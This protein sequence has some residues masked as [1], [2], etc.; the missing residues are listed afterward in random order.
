MA[1]PYV[2]NR[3]GTGDFTINIRPIS[4]QYGVFLFNQYDSATSSAMTMTNAA[5]IY[6]INQNQKIWNYGIANSTVVNS[7]C[8]MYVYSKGE[9]NATQINYSGRVYV[10]GGRLSGCSVKSNGYLSISSGGRGE[11]I[12]CSRNASVDFETG[13]SVFGLTIESCSVSAYGSGTVV[14][15]AVLQQGYCYIYSS[16]AIQNVQ[17]Y[18]SASLQVY[19]AGSAQNVHVYNGGTFY[20]TNNSG[21]IVSNVTLEAG[22]RMYISQGCS[23]EGI[24][25]S[26]GGA[27]SFNVYGF[28]SGTTITG[29]NYRG[30]V[31][32]SNGVASGF[33]FISGQSCFVNYGASAINCQCF[34]SSYLYIS[35]GARASNCTLNYNASMFV[36]SDAQAISTTVNSYA[37]IEV[38]ESGV[39]QDTQINSGG[40]ENIRGRGRS[41]RAQVKS[42]GS[43][44]LQE[45]AYCESAH[46]SN[47]GEIRCSYYVSAFA[48]QMDPGAS[49]YDPRIIADPY[50]S[51][52][53]KFDTGYENLVFSGNKVISIGSGNDVLSSGYSQFVVGSTAPAYLLTGPP[54]RHTFSTAAANRWRR[55]DLQFRRL[56]IRARIR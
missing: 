49:M 41:F 9:A 12:Y 44:N 33:D 24:S 35:N 25:I 10:S 27:I 7:N 51:R 34:S 55:P 8:S 5:L 37:Y 52:H 42:G 19:S 28:D 20:F 53:I 11:N 3:M 31:M 13:A 21:R 4:G 26:S 38:Y 54:A 22:A 18:S 30:E 2:Y 36:E 46:I 48:L 45:S 56:L 47:G 14:Q 40:R 29:S 39:A 1:I 15:D 6:Y 16:A 32:L 50:S 43:Q 17:V 23:V